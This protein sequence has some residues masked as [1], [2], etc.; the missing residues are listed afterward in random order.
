VTA[1]HVA[2]TDNEMA[3]RFDAPK[4]DPRE[5]ARQT[6]DAIIAGDFEI[7]A[8]DTTRSVRSRLSEDITALYAQRT[9]A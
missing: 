1:L 7:L 6:A 2:F 4:I 9:A 3:A 5:V 8:D